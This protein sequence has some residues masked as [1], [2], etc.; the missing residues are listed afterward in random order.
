MKQKIL[1]SIFILCTLL[2][3]CSEEPVGQTATDSDAPG[4][5]TDVVASGLPGAV[6]L[7]YKLPLDEDLLYVKAEYTVRGQKKDV[8]ASCFEN[9]MTIYGFGDTSLYDI[10]LYCVDRSNNISQ[11]VA[12]TVRP[13]TPP[14]H[15]IWKSL[16]LEEDFGGIRMT[17]K[18]PNRAEVAIN[19]MAADSSGKLEIADIVYSS[20]VDGRYSV[21]GFDAKQRTFAV[22]V[23]DRWDNYSD[24]LSG[25][26]TPMFEMK[27]DP[28]DFRRETRIPLDN[29][30]DFP[31]GS[32]YIFK[33]LFDDITSGENMW[34]TADANEGKRPVYFTIDLGKPVRLS[35]YKMWQRAGW[36]YTHHNPKNWEVWGTTEPKFE[37]TDKEYWSTGGWQNDWVKLLDCECIKPSGTGDV[38]NEDNEYASQGHEY[39]MPADVPTVRYLRF[40]VTK[41]WGGGSDLHISELMFWGQEI[42][43]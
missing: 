23:R 38:T 33:N 28:A 20:V 16:Q 32:N 4:C 21:R 24:T 3:A 2:Q 37:H 25:L 43:E 30:T 5:V 18:N 35:R 17:W 9:A 8:K 40:V 36:Y 7:S 26:Y 13:Q 41:T 27:I 29:L 34:H 1:Y 22:F 12:T 10:K 39:M 19:I 31:A 15:D 14:I 6:K 42:S 11:S